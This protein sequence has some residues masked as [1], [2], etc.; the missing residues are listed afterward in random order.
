MVEAVFGHIYATVLLARLVS[1]EVAYRV[2][3]PSA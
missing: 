2:A 3:P 1:L